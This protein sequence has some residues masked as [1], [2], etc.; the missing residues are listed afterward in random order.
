MTQRYFVIGESELRAFLYEHAQGMQL[1]DEDAS[2][3]TARPV[4]EFGTLGDSN[5]MWEE[6]R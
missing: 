5:I 6:T 1:E 3:L 4:E 2:V